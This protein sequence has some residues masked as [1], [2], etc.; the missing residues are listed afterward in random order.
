MN[1][2]Y[3]DLNFEVT[4]RA[5]AYNRYVDN[6]HIRLVNLRPIA[7]SIK[8][9]IKISSGK[10]IK[11]IDKAHVICLMH[12]VLSSSRDSDKLSISFHKNIYVRERE[13]TNNKTTKGNHQVQVYI[14]VIFGVV[15]HEDSCTY[16]LDYQ[17]TLQR[18][19]DNLVMSLPAQ[20]IHAAN[21]ALAG[22]VI[23][24]DISLYIPHYTASI[25]N[26][27]IMLGNIVSKT[28][29]ELSYIKRSSY[30]KDVITEN[31]WIFELGVADGIDTPIYVIVG[32]MQKDQFIRQHQYNDTFY[33]PSVVYA[34]CIIGGEKF[35]DSKINCIYLFD[36]YSQAYGEIVSC[37]RHLA[38]D[39][40]IQPYTTQKDF[41]I[42]NNYPEG[43]P[44][45]NLQ[46]FDIRHHQDYSTAQ[47]IKVRYGFRPAVPTATN[48]IGFALL[49]TNK[50]VFVSSDGQRQFDLI[51]V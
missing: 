40:L 35:P 18:S 16:G 45:Y 9:R 2:S 32:F 1:D 11:E 29:T 14:K 17:L 46:V 23:I 44:G 36:E 24:D 6:D 51:K 15:E 50:L 31:F 28:P 5:G 22:R 27:K 34:Q 48:L 7:L 20:A 33:R 8:Y 39:I 49:L 30:M 47:P 38:E 21:L 25:S 12:N 4:H 26:Q 19:S 13:V 10:E 43:N 41:L 42:F 37:L 3:L